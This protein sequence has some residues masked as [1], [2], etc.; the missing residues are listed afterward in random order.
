[1]K[2]ITRDGEVIGLSAG[3]SGVGGGSI[4]GGLVSSSMLPSSHNTSITSTSSQYSFP[5][6]LIDYSLFPP[7]EDISLEDFEQ[8][9]WS[10]LNLLRG[11]EGATNRFTFTDPELIKTFRHLED[12]WM[13]LHIG[14]PERLNNGSSSSSNSSWN[15]L[16]ERKRDHASHYI[17]RLAFFSSQEGSRWFQQQENLL[18]RLRFTSLTIKERNTF[19][20][21]HISSYSDIVPAT[22][23][24][25]DSGDQHLSTTATNIILPWEM[26]PDLVIKRSITLKR[27]EATVPLADAFSISQT[28]FREQLILQMQHLKDNHHLLIGDERLEPLLILV[29]ELEVKETRKREDDLLKKEMYGLSSIPRPLRAEM[30]DTIIIDHLPPCMKRLYLQGKEKNHL[31]YQGREQLSLFFK[32]I[33]FEIEESIKIWKSLFVPRCGEAQFSKEY[34]YN[35]RHNYGLEGKRV[36]YDAPPCSRIVNGQGGGSGSDEAHGCPFRHMDPISLTR[37]LTTSSKQSIIPSDLEDIVKI[38]SQ[39]GQCQQACSKYLDL[40]SNG[41]SPSE[42]MVSPVKYFEISAARRK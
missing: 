37:L 16:M 30:M 2:R 5:H 42:P 13:P 28:I 15:L 14:I 19:L 25:S 17:L 29:R 10:R 3:G 26:V 34:L 6:R 39:G 32:G 36:S 4:G 21:Y 18:F 40:I 33:G 35:I 12:K 20:Q 22:F 24:H 1:M 9:A 38:G 23:V 31:K 41:Y 8:L 27:G 11:I 7:S